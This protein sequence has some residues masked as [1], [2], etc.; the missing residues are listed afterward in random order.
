MCITI[1]AFVLTTS[2]AKEVIEFGQKAMNTVWGMNNNQV[3][4]EAQISYRVRSK[5]LLCAP[6]E[7][8]LNNEEAFF[9][10]QFALSKLTLHNA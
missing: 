3:A 2:V 4:E 5:I 7:T 8:T 9:A 10:T 6:T 1:S